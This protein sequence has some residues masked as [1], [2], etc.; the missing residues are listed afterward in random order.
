MNRTSEKF[1]V[2]TF[3]VFNE[4][5]LEKKVVFL[6]T[7]HIKAASDDFIEI[8]E[9]NTGDYVEPGSVLLRM[10]SKE[11]AY[12]LAKSKNEFAISL[13][14][15]GKAVQEE[16]QQA[17]DLAQDKLENT[18]IRSPIEGY[19]LSVPV[20]EK[21]YVSKGTILFEILPIDAS[22]Y[23]QMTSEEEKLLKKA[24][25]IEIVLE[26][27]NSKWLLEEIQITEQNNNRFLFLSVD[28]AEIA[29]DFINSL[30]CKLII[31]FI[32]SKA[33]W[34]PVEFVTDNIVFLE[35]NQKKEIQIL[36]REND[37]FLVNGLKDGDILIKKR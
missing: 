31:T 15:S 5:T 1:A 4:K 21:L 25:F 14:N 7:L 29:Q 34:I 28:I 22:A 12:Q 10:E 27:K 16:K 13:L 9:K 32:D 24:E 37:L 11:E 6:K 8:I 33:S 17:V 26:P 19:V 20:S 3:N 2:S 23:I 18:V 36:E 30:Y 35:D